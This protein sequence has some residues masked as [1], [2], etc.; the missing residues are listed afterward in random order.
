MSGRPFCFAKGEG[1]PTDFSWYNDWHSQSLQFPS[2]PAQ[3]TAGHFASQKAR[4]TQQVFHG[5]MV[6]IAGIS[7]GLCEA[8]LRP[9]CLAAKVGI[10][11][12]CPRQMLRLRFPSWLDQETSKDVSSGWP[13]CLAKTEGVRGEPGS[14]FSVFPSGAGV[15]RPGFPCPDRELDF[16]H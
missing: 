14:A 3:C 16:S 15:S 11:S 10:S 4:E 5:I 1:N 13:F 7:T 9:C 2:W 8:K 6:G 12:F